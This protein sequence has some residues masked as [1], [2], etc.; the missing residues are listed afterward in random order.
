MRSAYKTKKSHVIF[1]YTTLLFCFMVLFGCQSKKQSP[2]S[3]AA[4][5][6]KK[7]VQQAI[8][9]LAGALIDPVSKS[10]VAVINATLKKTM[11]ESIKLCRACPFMIAILDR[12]GT[13]LTVYPPKKEYSRHY[14][15]YKLVIQALDRGEA[16]HG[17]LFLQDGSKLYTICVPLQKENKTVGVIVLTTTEEEVKQRWGMSEQEFLAIDFNQ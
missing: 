1:G 15:Q 16:C 17:Q 8:G 9:M 3:P 10:N 12:K 13:V 7:E 11:P 14:A 5:A 4:A 2:L 6:F